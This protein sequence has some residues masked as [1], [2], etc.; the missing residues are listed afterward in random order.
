MLTCLLSR[1]VSP[2]P[3]HIP[4]A[5]EALRALPGA[6]AAADEQELGELPAEFQSLTSELQTPTTTTGHGS[7]GRKDG[8]SVLW[9]LLN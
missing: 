2:F 6:A 7:C 9:L 3:E 4:A 1:G 8:T 5:A